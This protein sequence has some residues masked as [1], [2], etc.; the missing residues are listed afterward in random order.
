MSDQ[1]LWRNGNFLRLW[2]AQA[3]SLLGTQITLL[4]I[5]LVALVTLDASTFQMGV[6]AAAATLPAPVFGLLAGVWSDRIRRRP[7]LIGADFGRALLLATIPL[8]LWFDLLS[9]TFLYGVNL[10][11][12]TLGIWFNVAHRSLL[13]SLVQR[14]LLVDAN[15]K[16]ETSYSGALIVGPGLAGLLIQLVTAPVAIIVDAVSYLASALLL[17]RI[18]PELP[19]PDSNVAR[20][21]IWAEAREGLVAVRDNPVLMSMAMSLSAFNFFLSMINALLV[22]YAVRELGIDPAGL[23]LVFA[24]GSVGFPIG[25]AAASVVAKRIGIGRAIV[26]GAVVSDLALLLIPLAGL[27][28]GGAIPLLIASRIIATLTGPVTAINQLSLRQ[29]VTPDNVLGR[30]NATMMVMALGLAPIG[31]L[32]AGVLGEV[33]GIQVTVLGAAIGVQLGFVILIL[34]PIRSLDRAPIAEA[35]G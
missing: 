30:V 26:W 2:G 6:L 11:I 5:P 34:S 15:G 21:S 35:P 20:R 33:V 25:A 18:T 13:P 16:L 12:G 3:I 8:A 27:V 17:T 10:L 4:A 1:S 28:P 7:I 32:L 22:L 14:E 24:V 31:G 23:G 9:M 19:A 29:S